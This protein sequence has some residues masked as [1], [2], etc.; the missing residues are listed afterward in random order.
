[1][2][3]GSGGKANDRIMGMICRGKHSIDVVIVKKIILDFNISG[4]KA[5]NSIRRRLFVIVER[6]AII[7][8]T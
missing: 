7:V 8:K 2:V 1:M 4:R 5:P 6:L 3:Y